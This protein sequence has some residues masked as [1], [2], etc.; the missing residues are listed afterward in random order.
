MSLS[1]VELTSF[2][3][4]APRELIAQWESLS[5]VEKD[6]ALRALQDPSVADILHEAD[7][8]ETPV[9]AREFFT[10][11]FFIGEGLIWNEEEHTGLYPRWLEEL[12]YVLDPD[13]EVVEWCLSGSLGGGKTTIA[14]LALLY[15]IYWV[16]CL[17]NP[18]QF[19]GLAPTAPIEFILF[20]IN[21]RAAEDAG[22][23]R[24]EIMLNQSPYFRENFP[25]SRHRRRRGMGNAQDDQYKLDLPPALS[26]TEA[27]RATHTISRDVLGGMLD[28][29]NFIPQAKNTGALSYDSSSNAFNLYRGLK[30]RIQSRFMRQGKTIGSLL[31]LCS[32]AA[33]QF[34]FME[35]HKNHMRKTI[36]ECAERGERSHLHIT[37]FAI[38]DLV[39]WRYNLKRFFVL[40]GTEHA[41]S[42]ILPNTEVEMQREKGGQIIE[43]PIDYLESFQA[44]LSRGLR[45]VSG[46]PSEI[47]SP[48]FQ[49]RSMIGLSVDHARVNPFS[50]ESPSVGHLSPQITLESFLVVQEMAVWSGPRMRPKFY[51]D[52]P[53]YIHVD[54]SKTNC[55]TGFSM[56]CVYG[57]KEVPTYNPNGQAGVSR[58]PL[59]HVDISLQILPPNPPEEIGYAKI[60]AFIQYLSGTLNFRIAKI[61]FDGYQS[62]DSIQILQ[63]AG[64]E[65]DNL[66]VDKTPDPYFSL[67]SAIMEGRLRR[68]NYPPLDQ[69][70]YGL[71]LLSEGN[72][73]WV[74]KSV[75]GV[76]KDIS[77]S[78]AGMCFNCTEAAR[79]SLFNPPTGP[80]PGE[81]GPGS[82][83][84][85]PIVQR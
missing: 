70:L 2:L 17:R 84:P 50:V 65:C 56:G 80:P 22:L 61:T 82:R 12:C 38:Y 8:R 39:P 77:D 24:F 28:E 76:G 45:E 36:R 3:E 21:L 25:V 43:V 67:K 44:D 32:S 81:G 19:F 59:I 57:Y 51:P 15:K 66:S 13:N 41:N 74:E 5:Q 47:L 79:V 33:T 52:A 35:Q 64:Y 11:P 78:L 42:R 71:R 85:L 40:L 48:L 10:D 18:H 1:Q 53:R 37:E 62:T 63:N 60:R 4:H 20:N 49:D 58:A 6:L 73:T 54:L 68:Y 23:A 75:G 30:N 46:I 16:S 9:S 72:K 31:C 7:F 26:V 55:A 29:A 83:G 69:E 14:L 27:S 34:D